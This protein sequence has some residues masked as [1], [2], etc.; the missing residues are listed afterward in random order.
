MEPEELDEPQLHP[1]LRRQIKKYLSVECLE[2][3]R[4]LEFIRASND[5]YM[6]YERDKELFEHSAYLNERE[7]TEINERLKQE[8]VQR[9]QS[10]D[11]LVEATRSLEIPDGY[12]LP[13]F[14]ADNLLGLVDFLKKQI[15]HQKQIE[16]ELKLAKEA[17]ESATKAKSEFLSVM[18]HEIR[19]PLNAILGLVYL[20][21]QEPSPPAIAENLGT[22]QFAADNLHVLINDILDFSKIEAGKIELEIAD[23]D[24]KHLVTNVGKSYVAKA[25]ENGNSIDVQVDGDVPDVLEGDSLRLNQIIS[26]L[27]SNAVKFTKN[28]VVTIR[29]KLESLQSDRAT[30]RVS[31]EDTGIGIP[32]SQHQRIFESFTQASSLTTRRF[33]GTGLGLVI[34]RRLLQLYHSDI[35]LESSP[36]KGSKFFFTI[37][38]KVG[39]PKVA[40]PVVVKTGQVA[41]PL[42]GVRLLLVEDYIVN[43]KIAVKFFERWKIDYDLAENGVIGVEKASK[44]KYDL[45]LMDIQMPEMD[46]YTATRHI[47]E[48]DPDIPIIALTASAT[49]NDM[50][51][52]FAAGTNDYIPKPFNPNDLFGKIA[53]YAGRS[54]E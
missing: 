43:V 36:G 21:K 2:N 47:R 23:F 14:S 53:K 6:N 4:V 5:S 48:F 40:T 16:T 39:K 41:D 10:F 7:Y 54:G 27:V 34:S 3:P 50:D 13:H 30:M 15:S 26:N 1:L 38:L 52:S 29:L 9:K 51:Q 22:L 35:H 24:F 45:I 17:A 8:V 25:E 18:S 31:V 32:E 49:Q 37:R 20:M 28:G 11:K 12:D 33:G 42:E 19:T 44:N 46:G